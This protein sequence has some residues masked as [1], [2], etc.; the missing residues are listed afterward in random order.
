M[1]QMN[2]EKSKVIY[3]AYGELPKTFKSVSLYEGERKLMGAKVTGDLTVYPD[4]IEF[5]L[6]MGNAVCEVCTGG[7]GLSMI[8][9]MI[10]EIKKNKL[11]SVIVHRFS[12]IKRAHVGNYGGMT[13]S[14]VLELAD[15]KVISYFPELPIGSFAEQVVALIHQQRVGRI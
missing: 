7:L 8:A 15:G 10:E 11:P 5:R 2:E 1:K 13:K 6:K 4:R 12:E 3:Q 14:L 9:A